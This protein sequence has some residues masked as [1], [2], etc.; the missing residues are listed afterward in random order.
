M[1]PNCGQVLPRRDFPLVLGQRVKDRLPEE[2]KPTLALIASIMGQVM[3]LSIRSE[4]QKTAPRELRTLVDWTVR[5]RLLT[6]PGVSQI[7]SKRSGRKQFQVLVTPTRCDIDVLRR[8][9]IDLPE[10]GQVP[11]EAVAHI[12]EAGGPNTINRENVRRRI[13]LQCNVTERGVVDVVEEILY[14]VA[15][16]IL[17]GLISS[18]LLDF[19]AHPALFWF[20]GLREAERVVTSDTTGIARDE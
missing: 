5:Q 13:V 11:L 12:Y 2:I 19:F 1:T 20:Y 6:V 16:V 14:P 8:L 17:G 18:T 9:A 4:G 10:G 7:S 3:V 15:T